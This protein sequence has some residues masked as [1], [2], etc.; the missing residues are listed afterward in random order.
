ML[1]NSTSAKAL[2]LFLA[3]AACKV[4]AF[5][6]VSVSVSLSRTPSRSAHFGIVSPAVLFAAEDTIEEP[7]EP[8]DEPV[9]QEV[10]VP[11]PA[12][13]SP[14]P[15]PPPKIIDP[16]MASLTRNYSASATPT[17]KIPFFGEVPVDGSLGLLV[18][19]SIIAVLGVVLSIVV[20]LQSQDLIASAFNQVSDDLVN[21]ATNQANQV[22]DDDVCR[23]LCS[24]QETDLENLRS[25][26]DGLGKNK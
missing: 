24:S 20:G 19:V 26:M 8:S 21:S 10:S 12:A 2:L 22:Y 13:R 5:S 18:P 16:L 6:L 25:F 7:S 14:P 3:S 17:K 15:P 4:E 9:S 11:K 1:S 23:G